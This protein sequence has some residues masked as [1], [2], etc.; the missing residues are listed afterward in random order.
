VVPNFIGQALRGGSLTVYGDGQQT[1]SFCYVEDEIE[2]IVRLFKSAESE[3]VNI[4]NPH[5]MTI[6]EFAHLINDLT[7]NTSGIEFQDKR[8]EG[9]P[10]QRRPDIARAREVL[11]WEPQVDVREGLR[12]T[13]DFFKDTL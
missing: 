4:G 11:G 12:R 2:G 10:Q 3:P 9:D 5:E 6:L 1:R 7:G 13:I 8:I